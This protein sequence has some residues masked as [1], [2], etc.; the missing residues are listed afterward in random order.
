MVVT[1][2]EVT[3]IS[4]HHVLTERQ[5]LLEQKGINLSEFLVFKCPQTGSTERTCQ[6][7]PLFFLLG[8]KNIIYPLYLS[9]SKLL[10][11]H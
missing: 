1:V 10:W 11:Q 7:L 9:P 8:F 2:S 4:N 6:M 3:T 5:K